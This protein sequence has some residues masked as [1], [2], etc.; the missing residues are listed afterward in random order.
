M[1]VGVAR[2]SVV[3]DPK[4]THDMVDFEKFAQQ[5]GITLINEFC[6]VPAG[7]SFND[8]PT[9]D[10]L[11]DLQAMN[12]WQ[13]Q[14]ILVPMSA[15]SQGMS[16]KPLGYG[17]HYHPEA[18]TALPPGVM[19]AHYAGELVDRSKTGT[20][21]FSIPGFEGLSIDSEKRGNISRFL[22]H[23][24]LLLE[25]KM[26]VMP[27]DTRSQVAIANLK[28]RAHITSKQ[29][30]VLLLESTQ[31]I[32]P[33]GIVGIS[34]GLEYFL[35]GG[36]FPFLYTEAGRPLDLKDV[37][38]DKRRFIIFDILMRLINRLYSSLSQ[39]EFTQIA[40]H[41]LMEVIRSFQV[42]PLKTY[43][44]F[45]KELVTE[46]TNFG[47]VALRI[48][49][50]SKDERSRLA[51][52]EDFQFLNKILLFS[53]SDSIYA[54]LDAHFTHLFP[55]MA[56]SELCGFHRPVTQE[57]SDA[58]SMRFSFFSS[59]RPKTPRENYDAGIAHYKEGM[60]SEAEQCL[61]LALDGF[62]K[63]KSDS[64]ECGQCHAVLA[65]IFRD[66]Q[67]FELAFSACETAISLF[68]QES[69][70]LPEMK[71][72]YQSCLQKT[73][74]NPRELYQKAVDNYKAKKFHQAWCLLTFLIER[75]TVNNNELG[76]CHSTLASCLRELGELE[77]ARRHCHIAISLF[78]EKMDEEQKSD[79]LKVQTKLDGIE[80]KI[81]EQAVVI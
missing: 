26:F 58:A 37:F 60:L 55:E 75:K 48:Y 17:V 56:G 54:E 31:P 12:A 10:V 3:V 66:T 61:R 33:G 38:L 73:S 53:N 23:L 7:A 67:R 9:N 59:P 78:S 74:L 6:R 18:S 35:A 30:I 25:L 41:P 15:P 20:Y 21:V 11:V 45:E 43:E 69:T 70:L 2:Q 8:M 32:P 16:V 29:E 52:Q 63:I 22:P 50:N 44:A 65:S 64:I 49:E 71:K 77:D 19:V 36:Q 28:E 57:N 39:A 81:S 76:M 13:Q 34:Y 68:N 47:K 46:L 51:H 80:A 40:N 24:P 1:R 27:I 5:Q 14:L 62:T 72:K 79:R 4:L 42:D